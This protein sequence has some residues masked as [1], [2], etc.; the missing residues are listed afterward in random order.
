MVLLLIHRSTSINDKSYFYI[1]KF[2][3]YYLKLIVLA[4][5]VFEYVIYL[6]LH[7]IIV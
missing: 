2:T 7:A 5:K 6:I 1:D 3:F 4:R